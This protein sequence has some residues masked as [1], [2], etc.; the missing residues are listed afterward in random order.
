MAARRAAKVRPPL[1]ESDWA[2]PGMATLPA[3]PTRGRVC[4][5]VETCDPQ[6]KKLGIGVRRGGFIVGVSFTIEGGPTFY[7][8]F[9][10]EGGGNLDEDQVR[11]YVA[12]QAACFEGTLVGANLP[13]D[14]DYLEEWGAPF[15]S[16]RKISRFS[17]IQI[18]DPLIY[19]LH[20]SYS[21]AAIADRWGQPGKDETLLHQAAEACNFDP[22]AELWR[23]HSKYVG[24]YAEADTKQPLELLRLQEAKI[25]KEGVS[26]IWDLECKVLP[27]LVRIR[28]RGIR[29]DEAKLGKVEAWAQAEEA[30]Q[31]RIVEHETGITLASENV[32]KAT[33]LVPILEKIG[34]PVGLTPTG[35]PSVS[36]NDFKSGHPVAEALNRARKMNKLRTT[37]AASIRRYM[38][39][40]RIHSTYQQMAR[41]GDGGAEQGA[42]YGRLSNTDPNLQQQPSHDDFA[43]FWREIYVPEPYCQFAEADYSQQEPR[44]TTHFAAAGGFE[45]A[46]IAAQTYHDDPMVDSHSMM[47]AITGLPRQQSKGI[48]LGLCYGEGGAK[49]SRT[50]G[51]PTR[52]A[53]LVGRKMYYAETAEGAERILNS[54]GKGQGRMW[55]TA[56]IEGQKIID[57]FDEAVPYVRMLAKASTK[58]AMQQGFVMTIGGRKLHFPRKPAIAGGGYD[59]GHKALNRIIQ[60][61]GAD[62]TKEALVACDAAGFYVQLQVHDS[63]GASVA[64]RREADGI[65]EIMSTVRKARVPFR[66]D[67]KIG[68]SWGEAK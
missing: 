28:R 9:R 50:C 43:H 38:T 66:V 5:D 31:L 10:H 57:Q 58:T 47:A 63:I 19:E 36:R 25:Q 48:F 8:P 51:L 26:A 30:E 27:C 14:L 15:L 39:N 22:K 44:W 37:F 32:W 41:E 46:D 4:V 21:L 17:D 33:A 34:Q 40:G 56:G 42:R 54:L 29:I 45:G 59:W 20:Q 11:R 61:S 52:W 7:L 55:E 64:N 67:V 3:W 65:A 68:P 60:G 1:P 16:V 12:D 18:A 23:L 24:P 35:K 62:Q 53:V 2:P 49:L 6:L 13:Y